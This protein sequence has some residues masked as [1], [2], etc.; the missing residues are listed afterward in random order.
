MGLEK[1]YLKLEPP[2]CKRVL[3]E[4]A[5]LDKLRLASET[6]KERLEKRK[7]EIHV[8]MT[9]GRARKEARLRRA[10]YHAVEVMAGKQKALEKF[11][12][13]PARLCV[14]GAVMTMTAVY[15]DDERPEESRYFLECPKCHAQRT[16]KV[17]VMDEMKAYLDD[18]P[19]APYG[20]KPGPGRCCP[21]ANYVDGKCTGC[22]HKEGGA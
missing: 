11:S 2:P 3:K 14:C 15:S 5:R 17:E 16:A 22:G 9:E 21:D 1:P 10:R 13:D 20:I 8:A 19:D 6:A 7:R 4:R 12:V 18:E